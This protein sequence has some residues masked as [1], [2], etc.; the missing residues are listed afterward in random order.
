MVLSAP[1]SRPAVAFQRSTLRGKSAPRGGPEAS[2]SMSRVLMV[3]DAG[4]FRLL[5]ASFLR[6]LGCEIVRVDETPELLERARHDPP[7]LILLDADHPKLDGPECV[8]ALKADPGL[9]PTP[10]LVVS[11]PEGVARCSDAGADATLARPLAPG[12]LELA[13]S[14]LGRLGPRSGARRSAR[15]PVRVVF[16]D[17]SAP[18][19]GRAKDISCTG[20]FLALRRTV[21]VDTPVILSMRLPTPGRPRRL[22]ARGIVVRQVPDDPESHLIS[23]IGV[24]FVDLEEPTAALID[25][26]VTQ[27]TGGD[28][29]PVGRPATGRGGD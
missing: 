10:V 26:Y 7:D 23:G 12:A 6:R 19:R 28:A 5:E 20:V 15:F 9:R 14:A 4:L 11:S 29:P 3:D 18:R 22:Q 17:G 16:A 27:A 2:R 1:K 8:R 13:L 25:G 24:R 21:P